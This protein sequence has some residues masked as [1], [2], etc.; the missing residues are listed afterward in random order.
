MAA[1][2][3]AVAELRRRGYALRVER[4]PGAGIHEEVAEAIVVEAVR[5]PEAVHGC[6]T[7]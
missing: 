2:E 7:S 6:T 1:V 5:A 4:R 3:T